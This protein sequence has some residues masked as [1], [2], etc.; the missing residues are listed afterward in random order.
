MIVPVKVPSRLTD[1]VNPPLLPQVADTEML[2]MAVAPAAFAL[3]M[4][5][6][7]PRPP[8]LAKAASISAAIN[9]MPT[10]PMSRWLCRV[11]STVA[12]PPSTDRGTIPDVATRRRGG[13]AGSDEPI[14]LE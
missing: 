5:G 11:A 8:S 6:S 9:A 7:T 12:I 14:D 2:E 3:A 4:R 10:M 1:P 13:R